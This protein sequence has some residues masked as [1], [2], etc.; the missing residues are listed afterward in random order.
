MEKQ[1]LSVYLLQSAASAL[2]KTHEYQE[3]YLFNPCLKKL[4]VVPMYA[5]YA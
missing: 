2:T 4:C 5:V 3:K 1:F